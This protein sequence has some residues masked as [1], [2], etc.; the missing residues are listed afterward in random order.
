[1][2][3]PERI[4]ELGRAEASRL[5]GPGDGRQAVQDNAL[6][7][8]GARDAAKHISVYAHH[9]GTALNSSL[10]DGCLR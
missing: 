5:I 3:E 6:V 1:M 9:G 4:G 8:I 2:H 7:E 10:V